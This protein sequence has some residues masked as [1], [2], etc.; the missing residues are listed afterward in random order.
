[1]EVNGYNVNA[2]YVGAGEQDLPDFPDIKWYSEYVCESQYLLQIVKCRNTECRRPRSGLFRLLDNRFLPPPVKVKQTVDDLVLDEAGQFVNLPVNLALRL[3]A[4]LKDFLQM[5]YEYFCPT[6]G[7]HFNPD[8]W[9]KK[10]Q[11]EDDLRDNI[12]AN[13]PYSENDFNEF[14]HIDDQKENKD[15][16]SVGMELIPTPTTSEAL[17]HIDNFFLELYKQWNISDNDYLITWNHDG[18][19]RGEKQQYG[20]HSLVPGHP[21]SEKLFSRVGE[22]PPRLSRHSLGGAKD[23]ADEMMCMSAVSRHKRGHDTLE[24]IYF[25]TSCWRWPS[26]E[27]ALA[28]MCGLPF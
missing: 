13:L 5:P 1:M 18:E 10:I 15:E 22:E 12:R 19:K 6:V 27:A 7:D 2:K 25:G 17:R 28:T 20:G 24:A 26:S 9:M 8:E 14:V 11:Q 23:S 21:N 3:S 16:E 4:S